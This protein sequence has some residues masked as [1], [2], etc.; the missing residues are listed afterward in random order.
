MLCFKLESLSTWLLSEPISGVPN[1]NYRPHLELRFSE[2]AD[3]FSTWKV[4]GIKKVV[5]C[6]MPI[7]DAIDTGSEEVGHGLLLKWA[8]G[9]EAIIHRAADLET[10]QKPHVTWLETRLL[11]ND[12]I[13]V[14][15]T[16]IPL[17]N[18]AAK[19]H[20]LVNTISWNRRAT[21]I[22]KIYEDLRAG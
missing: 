7:T 17:T 15:I 11:H 14:I 5:G 8:P 16:D 2:S 10:E 4:M 1:S 22:W 20:A 12:Q 9:G 3:G 13:T 6:R 18:T 19:E 21:E